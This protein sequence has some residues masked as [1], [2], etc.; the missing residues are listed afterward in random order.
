[1]STE[2]QDFIK[3][4]TLEH[5]WGI[6]VRY[7]TDSTKLIVHTGGSSAHNIII[8]SSTDGAVI[9]SQSYIS[10][11]DTLNYGYDGFYT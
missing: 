8:L 5:Q 6:G 11:N 4:L 7:S 9:F 10:Y 2:S 1:M 3:E